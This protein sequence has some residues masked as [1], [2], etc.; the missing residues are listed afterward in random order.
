[1]R[2]Q[3]KQKIRIVLDCSP[4]RIAS[5]PP[6]VEI[7]GVQEPDTRDIASSGFRLSGGERPVRSIYQKY[8][9]TI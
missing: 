1:M 8:D 3:V 6:L 7:Q 2:Q 5:E 9:A 4:D